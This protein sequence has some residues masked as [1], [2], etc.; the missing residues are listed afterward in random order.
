MAWQSPLDAARTQGGLTLIELVISI[1]VLGIALGGAL[2]AV[3][4]TTVRSAD[5]LLQHQASAVAEAYL[6]EILLKS[7][8]DPDV[9]TVC[10]ASEANRGLYDNVCDYAGLDDSGARDQEGA[11]VTG[12][13]S[14]RVRVTVDTAATLNTLTGSADVLR[15][16]VRVNHGSRVD[17]TLSGYQASY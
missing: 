6:E 13:S 11:A 9:G 4:H 2:L 16:D 3:D 12:L 8:L 7:F 17:L 14:Y 10:P 5:P 15:V 1:A